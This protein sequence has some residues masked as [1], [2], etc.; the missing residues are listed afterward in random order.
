MCQSVSFCTPFEIETKS[1][2]GVV[3]GTPPDSLMGDFDG[4]RGSRQRNGIKAL[5]RGNQ[6]PGMMVGKTGPV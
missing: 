4:L 1:E 2:G 3:M 6:T 5:G